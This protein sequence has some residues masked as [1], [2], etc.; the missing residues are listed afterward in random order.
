[1][2]IVP[3]KNEEIIINGNSVSIVKLWE[4]IF[5][6]KSNENRLDMRMV[7]YIRY[8]LIKSKYLRYNKR[9]PYNE[10]EL[11][12]PEGASE[13]YLGYMMRICEDMFIRRVR[14][15][16][17]M[18][19]SGM[20]QNGM[21]RMIIKLPLPTRRVY[22]KLE[23]TKNEEYINNVKTVE[24]IDN[25]RFYDKKEKGVFGLNVLYEMM[26][27]LD[28]RED[29]KME[30]KIQ[31]MI[32]GV[33]NVIIR[34]KIKQIEEMTNEKIMGRMKRNI[35][36]DIEKFWRKFYSDWKIGYKDIFSIK[37]IF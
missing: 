4:E 13:G 35:T 21:N 24:M 36:H 14:I 29:I 23:D 27:K 31:E 6:S 16:D 19:V 12:I 9:S 15:M 28:D 8:R 32:I 1:M 34:T 10:I 25:K 18:E 2:E 3:L 11:K 37:Y 17:I 20:L 33:T 30:N 7:D 22:K 26:R 5:I